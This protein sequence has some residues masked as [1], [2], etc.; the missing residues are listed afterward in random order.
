MLDISVQVGTKKGDGF[1]SEMFRLVVDCVVEDGPTEK[2]YLIL[3]KPHEN[4]EQFDLMKPFDLFNRE[5]TFY[6][7]YYPVIQEIL[8]SVGELE[9]LAPDMIYADF[10]TDVLILQDLRVEGY[11][12]GDR[13]NRVTRDYCEII[14]RKLAKLHAASLVLNRRSQ[15]A[16]ESQRCRLF[17]GHGEYNEIIKNHM[18]A[19]AKDMK[20]W[21]REFSSVI[22]KLERATACYGTVAP[23]R[24]LSK[25]GL[26]LLVHGDPWFNNMLLKNANDTPDA[27]LIDFQTVFWGSLA[28]DLIYFTITTLSEEDFDRRDDF[29]GMYHSHL[30]RVLRKL[31]WENVPSLEDVLDEYKDTFY[32]AIYSMVTKIITAMDPE[33]QNWGNFTSDTGEGDCDIMKNIQNPRINKELRR[34]VRLLDTFGALD[35]GQE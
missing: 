31:Q 32:H 29:I 33:E 1:S 5:I 35:V 4:Q 9:N 30:E 6:Q 23:D 28:T 27:L 20:S 21:G 3:K 22:P 15:G 25:R 24:V 26:N 7:Q 18:W 19:L 12:T 11:K 8:E 17:E 10:E 14:L 16:L 13:H 34:I 2:L